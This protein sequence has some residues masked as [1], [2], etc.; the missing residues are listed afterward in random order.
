MMLKVVGF[1]RRK[2]KRVGMEVGA[3]D[4]SLNTLGMNSPE[5]G[6]TEASTMCWADQISL[7]S[8]E[9]R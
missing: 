5:S 9:L 7:I 4:D 2:P 6:C 8:L 3:Y 1:V